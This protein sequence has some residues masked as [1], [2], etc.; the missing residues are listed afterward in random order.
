MGNVTALLNE[1]KAK[2]GA[3]T[4]YRLAKN[5]DLPQQRIS[6]YYKGKSAPDEFACAKIAEATGRTFECVVYLV[7]ADAEKDEK[8]REFW[9]KKLFALGRIAACLVLALGANVTLKVQEAQASASESVGYNSPFSLATNYTQSIR[10][11]IAFVRDTLN[12]LFR[13]VCYAGSPNACITI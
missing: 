8:R 10:T 6:E 4:D 7:K 5:L 11:A 2:T 12:K 9:E 3:E 13:R 1:A